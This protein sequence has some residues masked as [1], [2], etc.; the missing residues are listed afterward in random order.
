MK[1]KYDGRNR[2][3]MPSPNSDC[4]HVV[5]R[6]AQVRHRDATVDDEPL[7]LVED[8][9]VRGVVLVG[10]VDAA[11][12]DD[13]DRW[14][15]GQHRAG[16]H[17]AGV[18]AQH[19]VVLGRVGPEGVLQGAR[20]VVG[21]EVERVEV[22]PLGL[23]ARAFGDLPA[24]RHED[25]G[26]PLRQGRDRV[27]GAARP[28]VP[29]QRDVDDLVDE[30]P[31]LGLGVELGLASG[32]CLVDRAT[33]LADPLTDLLA[34]RRGQGADLTVGQC[35]WRAVARV[36]GARPLELLEAGR[37]PDGGERLAR[38]WSRRARRRA[39]SPGPG[40]T[41]SWARTWSPSTRLWLHARTRAPV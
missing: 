2:V 32:Q 28:A 20:G 21:A 1:G 40:R 22:E 18:G 6:A 24:H 16:L 39:G 4:E 5:E 23:D 17:G 26:D 25:V 11:R 14:L 31:L 12:A 35:Q 27:P 8:R 3:R 30:H 33:R 19:E 38:A 29:G 34:C 36:L 9:A 41:R 7:D 37:L 15:A 10:A 13:V